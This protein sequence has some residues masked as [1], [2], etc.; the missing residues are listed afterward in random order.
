MTERRLVR[1][2][3]PAAVPELVHHHGSEE[4]RGAA[5]RAR[6][7]SARVAERNRL[8]GHGR[9]H[10][11]GEVFFDRYGG[12]GRSEISTVVRPDGRSSSTSCGK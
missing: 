11:H 1:V 10:A 7:N 9:G 5:V 6:E 3:V 2:G 4:V 8:I 12:T